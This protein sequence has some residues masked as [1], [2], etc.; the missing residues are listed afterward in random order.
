MTASTLRP[1]FNG[2]TTAIRLMSNDFPVTIFHNPA[3]GTSRNTLALIKSAGYEPEVVEYLKTGWTRL[4][5]EK[6]CSPH[7]R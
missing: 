7:G 4:Q 1:A 2:A 6:L 3:C 5:L